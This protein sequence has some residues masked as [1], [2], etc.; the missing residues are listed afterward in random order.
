MESHAMDIHLGTSISAPSKWKGTAMRQVNTESHNLLTKPRLC[1]M[2]RM[3]ILVVALWLQH[4]GCWFQ[5][6]SKATRSIPHKDIAKSNAKPR[7]CYE[8]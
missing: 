2:V 4:G 1:P 3:V 7:F 5:N 8:V 6:I